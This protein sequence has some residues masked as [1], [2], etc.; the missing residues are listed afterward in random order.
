MFFVDLAGEERDPLVTAALA[1][2]G[3]L[4]EHVHVL[5][6]YS[7]GGPAGAGGG[8]RQAGERDG[9]RSR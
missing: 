6:C 4:C 2:L 9:A 8:P 3:E 1:G 5:G 7:A